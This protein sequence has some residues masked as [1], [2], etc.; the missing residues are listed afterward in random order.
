[1]AMLHRSSGVVPFVAPAKEH[2]KESDIERFLS[3]YTSMPSTGI[4]AIAA[5]SMRVRKRLEY[6]PHAEPVE[7][8]DPRFD[9]ATNSFTRFFTA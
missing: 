4:D 3:T 5:A 8:C 9:T 6:S 7:A 2:V 1:M